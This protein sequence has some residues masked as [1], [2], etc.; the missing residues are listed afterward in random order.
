MKQLSNFSYPLFGI[1]S[2]V[3]IFEEYPYKLIETKYNTYVLDIVNSSLPF[4]ERRKKLLTSD[5]GYP[6]YSLKERF[7]SLAQVLNSSKRTFIDNNGKLVKLTRTKVYKTKVL[8]V[9]G[10]DTTYDGNFLLF[11]LRDSF[12]CSVLYNYVVTINF[13]GADI[14]VGG[15]DDPKTARRNYKI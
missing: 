2:Y 10:Y 5:A 9:L 14:L 11:T 15:V 8:K 6:M 3:R 12:I 4:V 13:N 7:T 1:R